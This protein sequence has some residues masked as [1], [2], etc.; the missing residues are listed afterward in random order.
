M[1][2]D[3]NQEH[4]AMNCGYFERMIHSALVVVDST[5]STC[6]YSW[7][8]FGTTATKN[9]VEQ[10]GKSCFKEFTYPTVDGSGNITSHGYVGSYFWVMKVP[11]T[12]L[13]AVF[14]KLSLSANC[15]FKLRLRIN[16]G[17]FSVKSVNGGYTHQKSVMS[18]G[19]T[20]PIML[21]SSA[22]GS[23]LQWSNAN[24]FLIADCSRQTHPDVPAS[25]V[26]S[27]TNRAAQGSDLLLLIVYE[28]ELEL[29]ALTGEVYRSD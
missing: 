6:S 16:Q 14:I 18:L 27:G 10:F 8:A 7:P 15:Q 2:G 28:R 17:Q 5:N 23:P 29:D 19:V 20:C 9:I 11:L 13:R 12:S 21:S 1:S 22:V 4:F 3:T 24:R 25:I 26:V